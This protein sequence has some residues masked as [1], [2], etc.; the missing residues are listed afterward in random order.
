[1]KTPNNRDDVQSPI[2]STG[3]A[4]RFLNLKEQTLRM[5][6]CKQSGPVQPVRIGGRL[7]WRWADLH[8]LVQGE[9][10]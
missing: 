1:M 10:A 9:A 8:K 2:A 5:W 4:A 3:Q 6:A 7:G